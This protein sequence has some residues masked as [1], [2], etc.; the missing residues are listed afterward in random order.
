MKVLDL[1]CGRG[2]WSKP[3]VEDGDEVWGIDIKDYGYPSKLILS[4]IRELDGYGFSDVDLIIGS[5]PC[6]FYSIG[7]QFQVNKGK[8]RDIETA[9]KLVGEFERFVR[10]AQPKFW[11]MENVTNMERYYPTV[12]GRAPSWHFMISAG[13]RRS[14]WSNISLPLNPDYQFHRKL[15]LRYGGKSSDQRAEIPYPIARFV[16]D[17]VKGK[18]FWWKIV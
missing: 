18:V 1:F 3:F 14:L 16:A 13:G 6:T 17:S 7:F 2:G 8:K 10:E 4:D 12:L 5:P 11:A 15:Y 9:N